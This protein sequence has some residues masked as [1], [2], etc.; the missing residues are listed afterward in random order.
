MKDGKKQAES[1]RKE[2]H[3]YMSDTAY[4]KLDEV[5][6]RGAA[7]SVPQFCFSAAMEKALEVAAAQKRAGWKP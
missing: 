3:I 6:K 7:S 4:K 2:V 5:V 1:R